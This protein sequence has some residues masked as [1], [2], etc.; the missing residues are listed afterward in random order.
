V[1]SEDRSC[2]FFHKPGFALGEAEAAL[3]RKGLL[4]VSRK[5]EFLT[6][7]WK[8]SPPLQIH[9]VQG[10]GVRKDA[11]RVSRGTVLEGRMRDFDAAFV[12]TFENLDDVLEDADTLIEVQLELREATDAV[13]S[14]TWNDQLSGPEDAPDP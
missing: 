14:R 5:E 12:I 4:R 6:V 11:T 10:E 2:I 7:T 9:Y 3:R 8:G 13:I 1:D